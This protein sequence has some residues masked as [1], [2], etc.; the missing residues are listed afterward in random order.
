M[1]F[2]RHSQLTQHTTVEVLLVD[3]TDPQ[4][5]FE[6]LIRFFFTF[7]DPT[8]KNRQGN[9]AGFQYASYIFCQDDEQTR[10]AQKVQSELQSYLDA[11]PRKR[12]FSNKTVTTK[13]GPL[14]EFTKAEEYHQRYL[15]NNPSGYWYVLVLLSVTVS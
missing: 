10:I 6:E 14:M 7:H 12:P 5:H 1:H 9:D 3:L 13:I 2:S 8:T 4:K 15:E 11:N